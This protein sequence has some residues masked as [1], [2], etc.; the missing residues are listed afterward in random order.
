[1]AMRGN[2]PG[3]ELGH[4]VASDPRREQAKA[5][6][7]QGTNKSEIARRLNVDRRTIHRW[8]D[9]DKWDALKTSLPQPERP[10][11]VTFE[12]PRGEPAAPIKERVKVAP[13]DY[14]SLEGLLSAIDD[15]I[16]LARTELSCPTIPQ[17]FGAATNGLVKLIELRLKVCPLDNAELLQ[18]LQSRYHSPREL[19]RALREQGFGKVG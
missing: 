15:A 4:P 11:V 1:M 9:A 7:L 14:D 5:L 6:Y 3:V 8:A 16:A 2:P 13:G 12:R 10:K 17:N 18:L 19:V